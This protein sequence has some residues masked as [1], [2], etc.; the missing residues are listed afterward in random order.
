M[1]EYK[2]EGLTVAGKPVS[3]LINADNLKDAKQ[4]G[5]LMSAEKKFKLVG[6]FE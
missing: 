5:S 2:I 6:V 1:A 3:G 4:K